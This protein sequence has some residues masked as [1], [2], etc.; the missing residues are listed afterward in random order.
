MEDSD[1]LSDLE[2]EAPPK[3]SW[4]E[5]KAQLLRAPK[6][7]TKN[8]D[9]CKMLEIKKLPCIHFY[10]GD[11]GKVE[12]FLCGPSKF[13]Q[14][15]DRLAPYLRCDPRSDEPCILPSLDDSVPEFSEIAYDDSKP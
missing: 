7:I 13:P 6:T 14:V 4:D 2:L 12:D 5:L 8:K 3:L 9:L 11:Y 15:H 10:A 1:S